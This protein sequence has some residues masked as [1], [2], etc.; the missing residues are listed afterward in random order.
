MQA[1]LEDQTDRVQA[2]ST[3]LQMRS[4]LSRVLMSDPPRLIKLG[5]VLYCT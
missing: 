4:L 3:I 2:G 5:A 1:L